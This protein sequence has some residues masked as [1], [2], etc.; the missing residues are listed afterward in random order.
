[1]VTADQVARLMT[2]AG[3]KDITDDDIKTFIGKVWGKLSKTDLHVLEYDIL[4][5]YLQTKP[6]KKNSL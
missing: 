5:G 4:C 3:N 6:D 1:V 2:I